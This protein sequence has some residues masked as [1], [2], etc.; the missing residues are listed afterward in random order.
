MAAVI[1]TDTP[2][3]GDP[4][5]ST[6]VLAD[7]KGGPVTQGSFDP[8]GNGGFRHAK[9]GELDWWRERIEKQ[10]RWHRGPDAPTVTS[11]VVVTLLFVAPRRP[12]HPKYRIWPVGT[13]GDVDKLTRAAIDGLAINTR[14]QTVG[15]GDRKRKLPYHVGAGVV[16]DDRKVI[17][18]VAMKT[19]AQP[20]EDPGLQVCI[21]A[22]DPVLERA[23]WMP[24]PDW[25]SWRYVHRDMLLA[26]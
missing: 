5:V 8:T 26:V 23:G 16:D 22:L 24:V 17:G 15:R 3:I 21:W 11:A 18:C 2:T 1:P 4:I 7:P 13:E 12:S 10:V 25:P 19:Y 20:G 9:K 14:Y 6:F